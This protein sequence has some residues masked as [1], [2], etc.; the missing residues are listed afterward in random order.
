MSAFYR[1]VCQASYWTSPELMEAWGKPH[2]LFPEGAV[3]ELLGQRVKGS[4][5]PMAL[6]TDGVLRGWVNRHA[7]EPVPARLT[8]PRSALERLVGEDDL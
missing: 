1:V 7:L 6:V 5:P 4:G 8:P 3:V 2:G